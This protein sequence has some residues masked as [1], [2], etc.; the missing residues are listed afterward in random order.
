MGER[1]GKLGD[2][3]EEGRKEANAVVES[4]KG[5]EKM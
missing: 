5:K 1:R 2:K 3:G 4:L